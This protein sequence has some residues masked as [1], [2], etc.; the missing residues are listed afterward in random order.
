MKGVE[1]IQKMLVESLLKRKDHF[2]EQERLRKAYL[3]P[4]W[5]HTNAEYRQFVTFFSE[6]P[7]TATAPS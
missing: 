6:R 3:Q 5:A 7:L 2:S 1:F 4:K